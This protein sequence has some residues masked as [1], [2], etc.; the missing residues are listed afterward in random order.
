[1]AAGLSGTV[2]QD[3]RHLG[4]KVHV[5]PSLLQGRGQ[6][7]LQG[8]LAAARPARQ[9]VAV[10]ELRRPVAVLLVVVGSVVRLAS[11]LQLLAEALDHLARWVHGRVSARLVPGRRIV[12]GGARRPAAHRGRAHCPCGRALGSAR[13]TRVQAAGDA[14]A[15]STTINLQP[16]ARAML[17]AG[18]LRRCFSTSRAQ[19]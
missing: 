7:V 12:G 14:A 10:D 6:R 4:G 15:C 16:A 19:N 5:I 1:M 9:A 18:Q 11:A 3:G 17:S 13:S 2:H 8:G